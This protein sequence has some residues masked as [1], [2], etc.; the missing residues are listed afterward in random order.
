MVHELGTE[1]L[2]TPKDDAQSV[3]IPECRSTALYLDD[4]QRKIM[5]EYQTNDFR[6]SPLLRKHIDE[7]YMMLH[8]ST[9]ENP[10]PFARNREEVFD[11]VEM[12]LKHDKA[13]AWTIDN[14]SVNVHRG[15][16]TAEIWFVV[17]ERYT[18][19]GQVLWREGCAVNF[20]E[21]RLEDGIW[22]AYRY[23]PMIPHEH[24]EH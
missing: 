2:D 20:F 9:S 12:A 14:V 24:D 8:S 22:V 6:N 21:R 5:A 7:N 4:L 18:E 23:V 15:T 13:F 11:N 19:K 16:R 17:Q 3:W 1:E 10:L